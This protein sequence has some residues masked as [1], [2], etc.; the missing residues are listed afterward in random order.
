MTI[1]ENFI[2]CVLLPQSAYSLL[3][4]LKIL[5]EFCRNLTVFIE[6]FSTYLCVRTR[7]YLLTVYLPFLI[8]NTILYVI[9]RSRL[10]R[11][12]DLKQQDLSAK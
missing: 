1:S 6:R 10:S 11:K 7:A 4:V 12:K 3:L 8:P 2:N 9:V 5:D